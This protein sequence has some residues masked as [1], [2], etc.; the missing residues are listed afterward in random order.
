MFSCSRQSTFD[1]LYARVK[2][3]YQEVRAMIIALNFNVFIFA[4]QLRGDPHRVPIRSK[5]FG[6]G[7][8]LNE[9]EVWK[10]WRLMK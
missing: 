6:A 8:Q 2:K 7:C 10:W 9:A 5:R 4:E 3:L 1:R